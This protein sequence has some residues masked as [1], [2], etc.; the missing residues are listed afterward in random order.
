[1][2]KGKPFFSSR[3]LL[4]GAIPDSPAGH[5]P[6]NQN[7]LI[8]PAWDCGLSISIKNERARISGKKAFLAERIQL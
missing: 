8:V 2:Q 5:R 3:T 7:K 1:M 4:H 6:A